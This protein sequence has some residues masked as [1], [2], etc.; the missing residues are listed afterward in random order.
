MAEKWVATLTASPVLA[1]KLSNNA[2]AALP[3]AYLI[4]EGDMT[5]PKEYQ[6]SMV[7][8]QAQKTGDFTLSMSLGP[9]PSSELDG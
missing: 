4:L 3:C 8:L 9:F 1:T 5:L 7:A 6:E 2:Y